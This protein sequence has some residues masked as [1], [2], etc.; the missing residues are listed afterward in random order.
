MNLTLRGSLRPR[1]DQ[2][3]AY[4]ESLVDGKPM[5]VKVA[6][7][8]ANDQQ[9]TEELRAIRS[10]LEVVAKAPE[11]EPSDAL[12]RAILL[13]ARRMRQPEQQRTLRYISAWRGLVYGT[14]FTTLVAASSLVVFGIALRN[15]AASTAVVAQ[16]VAVPAAAQETLSADALN[17]KASEVEALAAAVQSTPRGPGSPE[18][19]QRLRAVTAVDSDLAAALKALERNPG[20]ARATHVVYTS[21]QRQA[22]SLREY[23]VDRNL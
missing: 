7:A 12:T 11:L 23:Y 22:D 20:S 10:S 13:E 6:G 15:P 4:A 18:G 16:G 21:L 9:A 8:I 1:H 19:M 14:T 17:R 5:P 2:V 3:L